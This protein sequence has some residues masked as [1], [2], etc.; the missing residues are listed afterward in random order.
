MLGLLAGLAAP[1]AMFAAIFWLVPLIAVALS[2]LALRQ[3]AAQRRTW[4]AAPRADGALPGHDFPRRCAGGR[5]HLPIL[6]PPR[7]AAVRGPMDR[8]RTAWRGLQGGNCRRSIPA[9]ALR[10][11][12]PISDFYAKSD[13]YKGLLKN[14]LNEPVVRSSSPWEPATKSAFT[15]RPAKRAWKA[16]TWFNRRMR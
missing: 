14:F 7:G 3:I 11:D 1:L 9:G 15:R 8:R 6:H 12:G 5:R 13:A 10:R 16:A 2:A 4:S